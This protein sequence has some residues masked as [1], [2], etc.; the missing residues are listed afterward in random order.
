VIKG[1]YL[2]YYW[3]NQANF[4]EELSRGVILS[5]VDSTHHARLRIRGVRKGD[6]IFSFDSDGFQA[7]IEAT[8]DPESTDEIEYTVNGNYHL[9]NEHMSLNRIVPLILD[10]LPTLYSPINILG[11]R[12]EGY[13]YEVNRTVAERLLLIANIHLKLLDSVDSIGS[14]TKRS[15]SVISRIIRDTKVTLEVKSMYDN[16]CQVCNVSLVTP[17]GK[18]S[19]GAHIIPLGRPYDGDDVISNMLCLCPNHHALF[20]KFAFTIEPSSIVIGLHS[21]EITIH[22]KHHISTESLVWHNGMYNTESKRK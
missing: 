15:E 10:E 17:K 9:L 2:N 1:I 4:E 12:C 8:S 19:E 20:D 5:H 3:V 21:G 22:E 7:V 18:Y 14:G 13:L 11:V 16:T 6:L